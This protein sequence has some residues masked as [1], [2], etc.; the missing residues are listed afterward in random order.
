[1]PISGRL[2]RNTVILL[3]EETTYGTDPTPAGATDALLVSNLSITPFNAN[4][5][6]RDIVRAWLGGSE[7]LVG[8]R[9]VDMSFDLELTGSGTVATAPAWGAA[10]RSCAMAETVT[11][12]FRVD[13]TP[14]STLMKSCTIYWYDDGLLHKA[15]GVRGNPVFK[16]GVG[17]RPVISFKFMGLYTAPT[18]TTN[19]TPTL[20]AWKV[21]QVITEANTLD[22][23][24]GGTH[25]L[26]TTP[27][28]TGGTAQV[29]QGLEI[30]LGNKVD[31]NAML[32]GETMDISQR[33]ATGKVTLDLTAAS[34]ATFM[35]TVEAATLQTVGLSH[36]TVANQKVLLWLPSV[37]LIN[38]QKVESNG[39][40]LVSFDMRCLPTGTGNDEVRLVTSF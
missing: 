10:L 29:S 40:R 30:D 6:D 17:Q 36:G 3:K 25:T 5:V 39:K 13:Y 27:A 21:P 14:V 31:F 28:I 16:M 38:P 24:F 37:Q 12:T 15:T 18:A 20:T 34:E 35:A 1:M 19:A 4:N 26:G 2:V 23:M 32:G 11:A 22:V 8:T 9:F 7:Q 33:T